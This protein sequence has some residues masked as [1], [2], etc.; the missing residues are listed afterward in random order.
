MVTQ[1]KVEK[2]DVVGEEFL[3]NDK[4]KLVIGSA[5]IRR[6]GKTNTLGY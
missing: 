5:D 3:R 1:V 4:I 6:I 2:R